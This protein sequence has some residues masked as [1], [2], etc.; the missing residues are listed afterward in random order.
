M[1]DMAPLEEKLG[2]TFQNKQLLLNALTHSSFANETHAPGGSNERL[3]FLGDSVLGFVVADYLYRNF[4]DWPEGHLTKTRAA[5]VCEQAC[6]DFSRQM[7]VGDSLRLSH[8][9]QNGGGRSRTSILADAFESITAAIYLDGGF[10]QA[11][12]FILRF[13]LPALKTLRSK[14]PFHDYKTKLQEII[15]RNPGEK[16]SYVL[17][18]ESGPD[19]DK[20]FTVEVHLNSNV[21]GKGGGHTK[22]DAEQQAAREALELMGY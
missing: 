11:R 6:C 22:K 14:A 20:H 17:T 5:L 18:G 10:Q 13:T 9:E 1:K 8:G 16:L 4:P 21:I 3:E 2:Y 19:H 15:Q 12:D 7:N